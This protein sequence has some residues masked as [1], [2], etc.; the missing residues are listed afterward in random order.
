MFRRHALARDLPVFRE[1][2]LPN[3]E[4]FGDDNAAVLGEKIVQLADVGKRQPAPSAAL[5]SWADCVDGLLHQMGFD[6]G[7]PAAESALRR[8]S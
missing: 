8:A 7:E 3:V 6:G 2:R 1:Q 4:Y 5:P